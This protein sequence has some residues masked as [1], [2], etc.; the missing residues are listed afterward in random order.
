MSFSKVWTVIAH[1]LKGA[2]GGLF[3]FLHKETGDDDGTSEE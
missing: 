1:I 3:F 2:I